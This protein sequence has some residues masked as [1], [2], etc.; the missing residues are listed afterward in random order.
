[1]AIDGEGLPLFDLWEPPSATRNRKSPKRV[2]D[3]FKKR[4][5]LEN[6]RLT[7]QRKLL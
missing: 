5:M 4:V 1:M 3:D 2:Y 7:G 6:T